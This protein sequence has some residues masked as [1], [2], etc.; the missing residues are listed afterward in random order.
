MAPAEV[1]LCGG[2]DDVEDGLRL[3]PNMRLQN[4]LIA[5]CRVCQL[6]DRVEGCSTETCVMVVGP[7]FG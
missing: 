2:V 4:H 3:T 7:P 6:P 1:A 5:S